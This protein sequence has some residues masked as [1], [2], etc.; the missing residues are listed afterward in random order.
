MAKNPKN[1]NSATPAAPAGAINN[2][3]QAVAPDVDPNVV[4]DASSYTP[5]ATATTPGVLPTPPNDPTQVLLGDATFGPVPGGGGGGGGSSD[6]QLIH[7]ARADNYGGSINI[8]DDHGASG[9]R[10]SSSNITA[11]KI[12]ATATERLKTRITSP[13]NVAAVYGNSYSDGLQFTLG[14]VQNF[15]ARVRLVSTSNVR[16]WLC[17]TDA[18]IAGSGTSMMK[19]AAP[20]Q[21]LVGF[22]YDTNNGDTKWNCVTQTSSGSSTPTPESTSSHVDTNFHT[23]E[24]HWDGAQVIFKIDGTQVGA[25]STNAPA[26]SL[27][28]DLVIS[29]D[30]VATFAGSQLDFD[31]VSI[32]E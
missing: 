2:I 1:W 19:S 26:T 29:T 3:Y 6:P 18:D 17:L 5:V 22:R 14:V 9:G 11:S 16:V 32:S 23:F 15:K 31:Y 25:Q 28:M 24:F 4:R 13:G 30:D 7:W 27:K 12:N 21:N 8:Y 20:N 10:W